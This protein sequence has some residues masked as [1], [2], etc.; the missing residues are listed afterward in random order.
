ME[1]VQDLGEIELPEDK[2]EPSKEKGAERHG[3]KSVSVD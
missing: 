2:E 3:E 1:D